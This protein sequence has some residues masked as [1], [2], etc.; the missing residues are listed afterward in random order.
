MKINLI[1]VYINEKNS[2]EKKNRTELG[3]QT[4]Y[5][6]RNAQQKLGLNLEATSK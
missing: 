2:L 4:I 1:R 6:E 5:K 3:N